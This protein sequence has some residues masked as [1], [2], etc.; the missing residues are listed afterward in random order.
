MIGKIMD[1]DGEK[2]TIVAPYNDTQG[3]VRKRTTQ[4]EIRLDDGRRISA[5]QRKKIYATLRDIS[6]YTGHTVEDLKDYT[7]ADY[8]AETGG[9]W[10]SLSDCDMTTARLYLEHI[11]EFCVYWDIPCRDSLLDRTPDVQRY[12]WYCLSQKKCCISGKR[13]QLHHVDAVGMGRDRHD[14]I[15]KGMRVLPLHWKYH[16]EAHQ[17][18]TTA[19]LD[20]YHLEPVKLD[21]CLCKVYGLKNF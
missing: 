9:D 17:I 4:C 21:D 5:D 10:F 7:K 8:I 3:L 16:Q 19:F 12:V 18:G 11:I 15:H 20:K 13:C 1:Y 14:I 2:L 6:D